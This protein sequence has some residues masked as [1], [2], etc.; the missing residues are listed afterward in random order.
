M[1]TKIISYCVQSSELTYNSRTIYIRDIK[2][3]KPTTINN[4]FIMEN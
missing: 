4:R 2:I 1:Y 3:R